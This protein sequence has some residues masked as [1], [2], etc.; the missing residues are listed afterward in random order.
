VSE[1]ELAP[2]LTQAACRGFDLSHEVPLR[3]HLFALSPDTHVL[4]ILLHHIAGDGWSLA[5]LLRDLAH[6]YGAR[7]RGEAPAF[8]VL[9]V[10]YADFTLWQHEVLGEESDP[11]SAIARQL[12]YWRDALSG[13]PEELD[14]PTDRPRPSVASYR[15]GTVELAIDAGLHGALQ[16]LARDTQASLFMVLQACLAALLSR[17][18]GGDDIAIGSPIAGRTDG[19]LDDLVGFFVNTLVLRTDVSGHPTFR[20]LIARVRATNLAAYGHQELP[21]ERLVEVLNPSR[22]LSRHP[23]FQVMLVLQNN[24]AP[25]LEL[26]GLS[27]SA[28]PVVAAGANVDLSVSLIEER[29]ADGRPGGIAGII[30]Y[31][32]DLFD[33]ASVEAIADRLIRLLHAAIADPDRA[34][35]GLD[36]LDAQERATILRGWNDTAHA[37]PA[38]TLPALFAAQALRTPDAVAVLFGDHSLSYGELDARSSRLAHHL[39]GLGVGPE[40]IVGLCV[41]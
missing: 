1:A 32:T 36:I 4:L 6:A 25:R 14:L 28:E 38:A 22:S 33:R 27:V 15:G 20:D 17:L 41:E 8:A 21:F 2:A 13:V 37:V 35:G 5:P 7:S 34:I 23:L 11:D 31:A 39:R 18:G 30:E 40:T 26:P 9:P 16:R 12:A 3:A 10:Q 19:A 29:G 24:A